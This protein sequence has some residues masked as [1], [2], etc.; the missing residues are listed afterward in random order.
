M[1][2]T[3][4]ATKMFEL[5]VLILGEYNSTFIYSLTMFRLYFSI[6]EVKVCFVLYNLLYM[7]SWFL[8]FMEI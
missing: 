4:L 7:F 6:Y 1:P 2:L 8:L 5:S 3:K